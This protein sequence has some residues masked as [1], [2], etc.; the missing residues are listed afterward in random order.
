MTN[1]ETDGR[2]RSVQRGF[3]YEELETGVVHVHQPGRTMTEYDNVLFSS[4]SM[5]PQA[6]HI[7]FAFAESLEPFNVRQVAVRRC[8]ELADPGLSC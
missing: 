2:P 6:M 3:W 4:L 8:P 1:P 7:D 5:N